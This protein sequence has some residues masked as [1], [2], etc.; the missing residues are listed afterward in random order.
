MTYRQREK[1]KPRSTTSTRSSHPYSKKK[2]KIKRTPHDFENTSVGRFEFFG[3]HEVASPTINISL[4][5]VR[6]HTH[7]TLSDQT[8]TDPMTDGT[9]SFTRKNKKKSKS[10]KQKNN[11]LQPGRRAIASP[12][13]PRPPL[14]PDIC[15]PASNMPFS[16]TIDKK[17]EAKK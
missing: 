7:R 12:I 11:K 16:T 8:K 10:T 9:T 5:C 1:V 3:K 13:V 6:T 2:K 4:S 17:K 14:P 15:S